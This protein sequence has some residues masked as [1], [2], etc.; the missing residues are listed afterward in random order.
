[1]PLTVIR[2]WRFINHFI[3]GFC[4]LRLRFFT[5]AT[6][7]S[8]AARS[9][10]DLDQRRPL[11][12]LDGCDD[13]RAAMRTRPRMVA[14]DEA[15]SGAPERFA[16][17]QRANVTQASG[18][19]AQAWAKWQC[20]SHARIFKGMAKDSP[21]PLRCEYNV[22]FCDRLVRRSFSCFTNITFRRT[23]RNAGARFVVEF[24]SCL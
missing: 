24:H 23:F 6:L 12:P 20:P 18:H 2:K 5:L 22:P 10:F 15:A 13:W 16:F 8:S 11:P 9:R 7:V 21:A 1:M 17:R 4:P 14:D 19:D 3:I